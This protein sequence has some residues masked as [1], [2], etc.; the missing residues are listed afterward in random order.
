M[1]VIG[2]NLFRSF[3]MASNGAGHLLLVANVA[4]QNGRNSYLRRTQ[5]GASPGPE[6]TL[7]LAVRCCDAA[8]QTGRSLRVQFEQSANCRSAGEASVRLAQLDI[9]FFRPPLKKR[10]KG[11]LNKPHENLESEDEQQLELAGV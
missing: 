3:L 7:N 1:G 2:P 9:C 8:R 10:L 6:P 4:C 11:F 5:E